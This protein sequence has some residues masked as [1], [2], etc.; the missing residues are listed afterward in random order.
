[1]MAMHKSEHRRIQT[2]LRALWRDSRAA[3]MVEMAFTIPFLVT[4]GLAG[5]ELGNLA[6][7]HTRVSQLGLQTADNAARIAAGSAMALPQIREVDVNE[8]FTGVA[9]QTADINFAT[10]GRIFLSSLERNAQGG[11]WVHWQRCFGN[12]NVASSYGKQGNGITGT[13]F[14]GMGPAGRQV[15]AS[16][17]TAVM[18]VEVV[19]DYEPLL[20][21]SWV[22]TKR[23]RSTAAFNVREPRD[24]S[25]LFNPSPAVTPSNC[26]T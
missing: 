10:R 19:Y 22:G 8:I 5:I 11:Q 4:V 1:M 6:L 20:F 9:K 7:V 16:A 25:Q 21:A 23:I 24:M 14:T 13:G 17:G 15:T 3:V 2:A 26:P 18:F 12:L